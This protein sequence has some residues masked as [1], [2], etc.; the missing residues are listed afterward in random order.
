MLPLFLAVFPHSLT[1]MLLVHQHAWELCV[2]VVLANSAASCH[3]NARTT[4]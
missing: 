4:I 2:L 3:H 1:V